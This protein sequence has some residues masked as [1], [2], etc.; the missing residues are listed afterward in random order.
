M[1][2]TRRK[3]GNAAA[4][5]R[6]PHAQS[7]LSFGSK[8]RVTKPSATSSSTKKA[9]DDPALTEIISQP[10]STPEPEQLPTSEIAIRQQA[11]VEVAQPKSDD[12]R[13]AGDITDVQLKRYWKKEEEKRKAPRGNPCLGS[14]E[15]PDADGSLVKS[16]RKA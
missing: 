12:E 6:T 15:W 4:A 14:L 1:P 13:K 9:K 3:A 10:I 2:L 16:T 11:K 7:T 5:A 8:S